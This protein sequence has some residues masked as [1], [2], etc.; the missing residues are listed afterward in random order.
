MSLLKIL[1]VIWQFLHS[2]QKLKEPLNKVG[3]QN[4]LCK[5][6][7]AI[8]RGSKCPPH[9]SSWQNANTLLCSSSGRHLFM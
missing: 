9:A 7:S 6:F 5:T 2:F 1:H 4:P 3:Q 8:L